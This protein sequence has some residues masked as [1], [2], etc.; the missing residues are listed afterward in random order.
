MLEMSCVK[1]RLVAGSN[2][3]TSVKG[4]FLARALVE[5]ERELVDA[6]VVLHDEVHLFQIHDFFSSTC[7]R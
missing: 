1:L 3:R 7:A 6:A 2:C 5:L 4:F